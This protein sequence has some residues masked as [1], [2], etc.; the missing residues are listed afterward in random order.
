MLVSATQVKF[1]YEPIV[2]GP[3]AGVWHH[4]ARSWH[5]PRAWRK[6]DVGRAV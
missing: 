1:K 5:A 6:A 4:L 3:V 2:E